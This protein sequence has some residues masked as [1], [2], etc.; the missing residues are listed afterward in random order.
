MACWADYIQFNF[1]YSADPERASLKNKIKSLAYFAQHPVILLSLVVMLDRCL[2]TAKRCCSFDC[3]YMVYIIFA[4]TAICI[5]G[6]QYGHYG[7]VLIPVTVYPLV[8]ILK[9]ARETISPQR[10]RRWIVFLAAGLVLLSMMPLAQQ[11]YGYLK[12]GYNLMDVRVDKDLANI[13]VEIAK[14]TDEQDRISVFGNEGIIYVASHRLPSGVYSY[15]SPIANVDNR[16]GEKYFTNLQ[17]Y[18][19]KLIVVIKQ[20]ANE[21][22]F[23]H[24]SKLMIDFLRTECYSDVYE[25]DKYAVYVRQEER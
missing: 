22:I 16:I 1:A 5:S 2:V 25:N 9:G 3:L 6:Q 21:P 20:T 17:A 14:R 23:S 8:L 12:S 7:M 19:P 24:W 10:L 13:M 18:K 15:Q 4:L 11:F